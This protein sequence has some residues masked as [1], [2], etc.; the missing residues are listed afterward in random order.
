MV[1]EEYM[2]AAPVAPSGYFG[3]YVSV[4]SVV[5]H[6]HISHL[7]VTGRLPSAKPFRETGLIIPTDYAPSL[8]QSILGVATDAIDG[9]R[10]PYRVPPHRDQ[11]DRQGAPGH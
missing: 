9:D 8:V 1:I 6:G 3:D 5:S 2:A 11:G 4:E 7:A 10:D